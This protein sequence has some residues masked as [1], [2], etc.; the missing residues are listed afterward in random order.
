VMQ[1]RNFAVHDGVLVTSLPRSMS[2]Q[3]FHW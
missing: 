1:S 3:L 2:R